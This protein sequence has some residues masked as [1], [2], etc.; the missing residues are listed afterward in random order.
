MPRCLFLNVDYLSN[1]GERGGVEIKKGM[2]AVG[3]RPFGKKGNRC[4]DMLYRLG[5]VRKQALLYE[6]A[7]YKA[8]LI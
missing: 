1:R 5:V 3:K 7:D 8:S 4:V 2:W 6:T